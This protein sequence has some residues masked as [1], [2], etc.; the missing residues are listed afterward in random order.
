[1]LARDLMSKPSYVV[2]PK[3]DII[4]VGS[5]MYKER[6]SG[7]FV[8]DKGM[9]VGI[10][11]KGGFAVC[12][13][14]ACESGNAKLTVGDV[15]DKSFETVSP[16]GS[17][18][19]VLS[20]FMSVPYRIDRIPVVEDGKLVGEIVKN[21]MVELYAE[22][23]KGKFKVKQLMEYKPSFVYDYT[24][25]SRVIDELFA[26][27][28]KRVL[29]KK[30]E[31]VV[32]II[33][34]LDVA[35]QVF[36]LYKMGNCGPRLSEIKAEDIMTPDFTTLKPNEDAV[37]AAKIMTEKGI[38]GITVEGTDIEGIITKNDLIKGLKM[39]EEGVST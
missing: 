31:K 12:V 20:K 25:L 9:V 27:T 8:V 1:M 17:F 7:A 4:S 11:T 35:A 21:R 30:G 3:D 18:L 5:H 13:R 32:G 29:V 19:S 14:Q 33:T 16:D 10:L 36:K 26:S 22:R 38:G 6:I 39:V 28:E 2:S 15:M 24:P 37:N 23:M 34:M